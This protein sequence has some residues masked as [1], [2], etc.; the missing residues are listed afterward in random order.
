[1]TH[2]WLNTWET[3]EALLNELRVRKQ[4]GDVRSFFLRR[5]RRLDVV[6]DQRIVISSRSDSHRVVVRVEAG[7]RSAWP[8]AERIGTQLKEMLGDGVIDRREPSRWRTVLAFKFVLP[9]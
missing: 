2:P 1:M 9:P 3:T 6:E 7:T 4:T 5:Q 8:Q